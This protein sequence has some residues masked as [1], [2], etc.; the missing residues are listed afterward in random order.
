MKSIIVKRVVVSTTGAI[1]FSFHCF[2]DSKQIIFY[3]KDLANSIF[4]RKVEWN[5]TFQSVFHVSFKSKY[6]S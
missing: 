1:S 4:F 6:K 3:D 5:Q 2:I